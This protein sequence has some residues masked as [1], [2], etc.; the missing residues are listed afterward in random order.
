MLRSSP[1]IF[2]EA[3]KYALPASIFFFKFL[4]WW[5]SPD[6]ARRRGRGGTSGSGG[7]GGLEGGLK[8]DPP[9]TL[10][11][12]IRGILSN[13]SSDYKEPYIP[14]TKLA[15]KF[16]EEME[17]ESDQLQQSTKDSL[18]HNSCPLCGATPMNNPSA[19]PSGY[20]FCYTCAFSYLEE[21]KRCPI[22]LQ[23]V[24]GPEELRRV[25]G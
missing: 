5:Y 23:S 8:L 15:P 2:F 19:L 13:K 4:E 3:L 1:F 17:A 9:K 11:P 10:L 7:P 14:R 22:T 20:V 24:E 18:L 25:L 16:D 6:N 12:H 21:N